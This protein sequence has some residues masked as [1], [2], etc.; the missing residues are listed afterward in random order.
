VEDLRRRWEIIT[1]CIFQKRGALQ[2]HGVQWWR[3]FEYGNELRV[4]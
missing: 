4:P 2:L 3:F 1:K